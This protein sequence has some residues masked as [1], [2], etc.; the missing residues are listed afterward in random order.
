MCYMWDIRIKWSKVF[1]ASKIIIN[2]IFFI[3]IHCRIIFIIK[4]SKTIFAYPQ[5]HFYSLFH[6]SP[7]LIDNIDTKFFVAICYISTI[8]TIIT[9]SGRDSLTITKM[10]F[11][12]FVITIVLFLITNIENNFI[13]FIFKSP[14]IGNINIRKTQIPQFSFIEQFQNERIPRIFSSI[15]Y[16]FSIDD[17]SKIIHFFVILKVWKFHKKFLLTII[18]STNQSF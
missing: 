7:V 1:F 10:K 2:L 15:L 6:H 12:F 14:I 17:L 5:I 18:R 16:K 9:A 3:I 13:S 11:I 8:E 4:W